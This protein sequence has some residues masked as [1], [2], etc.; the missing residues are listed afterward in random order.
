MPRVGLDPEATAEAAEEEISAG[1]KATRRQ[2][3]TLL[4]EQRLDV[5]AGER[6]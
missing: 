3:R 5:E 4:L 1:R 2:E 6:R